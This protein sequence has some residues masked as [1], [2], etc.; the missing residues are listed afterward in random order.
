MSVATRIVLPAPVLFL[1]P[2]VMSKLKP[3]FPPIAEIPLGL[4]SSTSISNKHKSETHKFS[5]FL[6]LY[7][8][9]FGAHLLVAFP[10]A[11][12]L[13]P[14]VSSINTSEYVAAFSS[15]FGP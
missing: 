7:A 12:A 2:L 14:Q 13:F 4:G 10:C 11:V 6:L 15:F 8:V 5:H 3:L 9:V 1:P